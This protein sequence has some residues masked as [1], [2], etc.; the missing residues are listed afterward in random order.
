MNEPRTTDFFFEETYEELRLAALKRMRAER[1]DHTLSAT[2]LVNETYIRLKRG[3]LVWS[4]R[5]HFFGAAAEAMRRILIDRARYKNATKRKK[6]EHRDELDSIAGKECPLAAIIEFD[7]QLA[8]LD[9]TDP[10]AASLTKLRVYGGLTTE[11]AGSRL[12]LT[13]WQSFE[14][15]K[16]VRAFFSL[17]EHELTKASNGTTAA[18]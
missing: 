4:S 9:A 1:C 10:T 6:P 13:R 18:K 5:A 2:A 3:D 8:C 12:G 11:E 15:W 16:F 17:R 7:E 14:I